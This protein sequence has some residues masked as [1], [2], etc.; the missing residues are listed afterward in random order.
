[1]IRNKEWMYNDLLRKAED[2][3]ARGESRSS[4]LILN[5]LA[6]LSLIGDGQQLV[7]TA[8]IT[9]MRHMVLNDE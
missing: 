2:L 5:S 1:M 3:S 6:K 4:L 8:Y 9:A 7:T